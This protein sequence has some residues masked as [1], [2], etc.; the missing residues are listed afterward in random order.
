MQ[1]K[2]VW[3]LKI[4]L[5]NTSPK[6]TVNVTRPVHSIKTKSPSTLLTLASAAC[7]DRMA[8]IYESVPPGRAP[9]RT[10]SILFY[11]S[12]I[13][14]PLHCHN[15]C[16]TKKAM[17]SNDRKR[18]QLFRIYFMVLLIHSMWTWLAFLGSIIVKMTQ[19]YYI[20]KLHKISKV[21][22]ASY[23]KLPAYSNQLGVYLFGN[24]VIL[25][26]HQ[27]YHGIPRMVRY[28]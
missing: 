12:R 7:G 28:P 19:N 26:C 9:I 3:K 27:C 11:Y 25:L 6:L 22:T 16:L 2:F 24:A 20:H 23:C 4:V 17:T 15:C 8:D 10:C 14:I 13:C 1:L 5:Q 21:V 18:A